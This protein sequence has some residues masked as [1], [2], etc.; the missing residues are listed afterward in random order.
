MTASQ[1]NRSKPGNSQ[2]DDPH[3][4]TA[5]ATGI[6]FAF[7]LPVIMLFVVVSLPE[8]QPVPWQA[9]ATELGVTPFELASGASTYAGS[10]AVCHGPDA[11]GVPNLGK[12]LRNSPFVQSSSDEELF[13]LVVKGRA[14]SDPLNTTG[15]LMPPRGAEGLSDEQ[16]R[17]VVAFM[18]AI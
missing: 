16:I 17:E 1:A 14:P 13:E 11:Q 5:V 6:L 18:R 12:P 9:E 10:C 7:P 2:N 4:W 8:P 15:A 3:F